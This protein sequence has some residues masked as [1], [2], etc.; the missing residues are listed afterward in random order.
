MPEGRAETKEETGH[1]RVE[2]EESL[3]QPFEFGSVDWS[4]A[5][6]C[7]VGCPGAVIDVSAVEHIS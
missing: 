6:P 2:F 1:E 3:L 7:I 5:S 4:Y